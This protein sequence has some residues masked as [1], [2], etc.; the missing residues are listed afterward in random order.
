M[1]HMSEPTKLALA[2]AAGIGIGAA[3]VYLI[4]KLADYS[5]LALMVF[6]HIHLLTKVR[7]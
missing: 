3:G 1:S 7:L 4:S 5:I 6:S 2:V